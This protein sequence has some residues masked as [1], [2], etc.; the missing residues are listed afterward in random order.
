MPTSCHTFNSRHSRGRERSQKRMDRGSG[1]GEGEKAAC[2]GEKRE[3]RWELREEGWVGAALKGK[4][5]NRIFFFPS[6]Y[7][8][9][10]REILTQGKNPIFL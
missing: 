6:P 2:G 10:E 8:T 9:H 4:S 5:G 7:P 1:G 3:M